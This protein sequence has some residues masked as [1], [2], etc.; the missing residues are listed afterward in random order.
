MG[1][2]D[3]SRPFRER[4]QAMPI[5]RLLQTSTFEPEQIKALVEAYESV[6]AALNLVDRTDPLTELVARAIIECAKTGE[7]DRSKLR[8]CALAAI[9]RN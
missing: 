9:M 4:S 5:T 1:K 3:G 2:A 7:F 8:T 6:L